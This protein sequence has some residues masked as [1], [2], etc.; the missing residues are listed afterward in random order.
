M[1]S[2]VFCIL[3]TEW[4]TQYKHPTK[5]VSILWLLFGLCFFLLV[6]SLLRIHLLLFSIFFSFSFWY[7][8]EDEKNLRSR[9]YASCLTQVVCEC[10][11]VCT[12]FVSFLFF[13]YFLWFLCVLFLLCLYVFCV[14][15]VLIIPFH[16]S[17]APSVWN[18]I[19]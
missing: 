4:N 8:Y 17:K 19:W 9:H 13:Y 15:P 1:S 18:K 3:R 10:L 16:R 7:S 5:V 2:I 12:W 6:S 11:S 14:Q